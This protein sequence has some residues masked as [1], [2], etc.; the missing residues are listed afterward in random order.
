M[1]YN[2]LLAHMKSRLQ[3]SIEPKMEQP[4]TQV[5]R[6][7]LGVRSSVTPQD[8]QAF[9]DGTACLLPNAIDRCIT[10]IMALGYNDTFDAAVEDL[11]E[12]RSA[13]GGLGCS[14]ETAIESLDHELKICAK[15]FDAEVAVFR[16]MHKLAKSGLSNHEVWN[17]IS[18]SR[19]A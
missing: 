16:R 15:A 9:I 4:S 13:M 12:M 18:E 17:Q 7:F 11:F 10:D 5:M 1:E 14:R 8:R 19:N 3:T 6:D 2:D